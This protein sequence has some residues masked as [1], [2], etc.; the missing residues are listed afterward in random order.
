MLAVADFGGSFY[1][2]GTE[3]KGEFPDPLF[4]VFVGVPIRSIAWCP[5]SNNVVV[6]C[7]GG[8][9]FLWQFGDA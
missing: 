7:V 2:F 4:R 8:S 1:I 9:L 5:Y 6:G 3:N